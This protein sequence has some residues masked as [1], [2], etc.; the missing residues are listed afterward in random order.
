MDEN[1]SQLAAFLIL[2][3]IIVTIVYPVVGCQEHHR[4]HKNIERMKAI[5][6][7]CLYLDASSEHAHIICMNNPNYRNL[8]KENSNE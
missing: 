5:E 1:K 3:F 8:N 6:N 4:V 7:G 2:G